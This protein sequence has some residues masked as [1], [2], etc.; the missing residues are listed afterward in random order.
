VESK[1]LFYDGMIDQRFSMGYAHTS[2]LQ[3]RGADEVMKNPA[4]PMLQI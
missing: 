3:A 4:L 1:A 2:S